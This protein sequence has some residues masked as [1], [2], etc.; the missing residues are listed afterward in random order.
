MS[1]V[2]PL[3]T[4]NDRYE[5]WETAAERGHVEVLRFAYH[6]EYMQ[7]IDQ[8]L[9]EV[10]AENGQLSILKSVHEVEGNRYFDADTCKL[11]ARLSDGCLA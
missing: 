11:A 5:A 8:H 6:S 9:C 3:P 1:N 4:Y 2:C 10:A 7:D